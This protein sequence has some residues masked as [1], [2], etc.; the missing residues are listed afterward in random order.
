MIP[1]F[2]D[3]S[4]YETHPLGRTEWISVYG[5]L[6]DKR[7]ED[8]KILKQEC[9]ELRKAI[10]DTATMSNTITSLHAKLQDLE[11]LLESKD[12]EIDELKENQGYYFKD[13]EYSPTNNREVINGLNETYNIE[14]SAVYFNFLNASISSINTVKQ[15][16]GD[17]ELFAEDED[18]LVFTDY[19]NRIMR[20][21]ENNIVCIYGINNKFITD[22][23]KC[24]KHHFSSDQFVDLISNEDEYEEYSEEEMENE[25]EQV[26]EEIIE[27]DP[28]VVVEEAE[29]IVIGAGDASSN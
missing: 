13:T 19:D 10:E 26:L 18:I 15:D 23:I 28:E 29:Q 22:S 2:V 7:E 9:G 24:D 1:V 6:L 25:E 11:D 27:E 21:S 14:G 4:S 5:V 3:R 17:T 16:A 20:D 12:K 8:V